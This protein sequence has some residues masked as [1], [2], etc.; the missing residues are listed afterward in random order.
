MFIIINMKLVSKQIFQSQKL[1]RESTRSSTYFPSS[2]SISLKPFKDGGLQP[3]R[4][5]MSWVIQACDSLCE[6]QR[7]VFLASL[8]PTLWCVHQLWYDPQ[9]AR[10]WQRP[11]TQNANCLL[12]WLGQGR[13]HHGSRLRED[14]QLLSERSA[15]S[16]QLGKESPQCQLQGA[17]ECWPEGRGQSYSR[18]AFFVS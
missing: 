5:H 1:Q 6:M 14:P 2:F 17:S 9:L 11:W 13:G 10:P 15:T 16:C 7:G 12:W 8:P 3:P 4:Y 18:L